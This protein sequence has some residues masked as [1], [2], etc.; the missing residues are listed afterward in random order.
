M[1]E[2]CRLFR[3][4]QIV[5]PRALRFALAANEQYE[6]AKQEFIEEM[7]A[8]AAEDIEADIDHMSI[9]DG[10]SAAR[11]PSP[12]RGKLCPIFQEVLEKQADGIAPLAV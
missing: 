1:C 7:K 2:G 3:L 11:E 10:L 4:L 5:L 12:D 9:V 6:V 8:R